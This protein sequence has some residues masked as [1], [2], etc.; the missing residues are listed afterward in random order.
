VQNELHGIVKVR[1][2]M[3]MIH[4]IVKVRYM[5]MMIHGIVKVRYIMMMMCRTAVGASRVLRKAIDMHQ[6]DT[7]TD[8]CC[9]AVEKLHCRKYTRAV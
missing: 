2:M 6:D 7:F 9:N 8:N 1:Y 3:M 5:M 4:G